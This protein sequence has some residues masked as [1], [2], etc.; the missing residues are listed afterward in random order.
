M[1]AKS[2]LRQTTMSIQEICHCL[3][4]EDA[5]HFTKSFKKLAKN[6]P[7]EYRKR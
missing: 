3:G 5:S 2:L 7:T 6:T 1:E 4:F